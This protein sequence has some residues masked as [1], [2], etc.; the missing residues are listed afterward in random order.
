LTREF[1]M[2]RR[3]E[4]MGELSWDR[5][6]NDD[7]F[8]YFLETLWRYQ[9][10]RDPGLLTDE[11]VKTFYDLSL[12][13][14]DVVVK[15]FGFAQIR[16]MI[17][18]R[19]QITANILR[20]VA[21]DDLRRLQPMLRAIRSGDT[22]AIKKYEDLDPTDFLREADRIRA[23]ALKS[24]IEAHAPQPDDAVISDDTGTDQEGPCTVAQALR[25]RGDA[26]GKPKVQKRTTSKRV[27]TT[28]CELVALQKLV[29]AKD[30]ARVYDA[31]RANGFA[32]DAAQYLG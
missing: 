19:E 20:S 5:M 22:S 17:V 18:G 8:R 1:L 15:L 7:T 28:R 27:A 10:V 29:D 9:Y 6:R 21:S 13:I 12:G 26:S 32:R 3:G 24:S 30:F 23:E 11:L 16:A 2:A 25:P 14:T 31:L 4:G